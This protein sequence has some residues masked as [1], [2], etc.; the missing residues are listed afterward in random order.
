LYTV[1]SLTNTPYDSTNYS[2]VGRFLSFSVS[3]HW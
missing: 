1:T 3:K 2:A